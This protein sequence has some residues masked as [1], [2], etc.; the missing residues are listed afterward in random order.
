M[1]PSLASIGIKDVI[2]P[3]KDL[4]I[5]FVAIALIILLSWINSR[6]LKT[7]AWLS[8]FILLI[9]FTGIFIIIAFGLTQP[10]IKYQPCLHN[11]DNK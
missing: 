5:K 3:F 7:G 9:V 4:N 10:G 2:E 1:L 6:G 11:G 8:T